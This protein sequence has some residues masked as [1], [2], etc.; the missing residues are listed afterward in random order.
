M[1]KNNFELFLQNMLVHKTDNLDNYPV[2]LMFGLTNACNLHCAFCPYCGFCMEKIEKLEEIPIYVLKKMEPFLKNASFINPSGRGE[3]L[4][5][6]KFEEFINI[7]RNANALTTMQLINNGTQLQ[8]IDMDLLKGINVISISVDSVDKETFELLRCGAKFERVINN[9]KCLRKKLPDSIL[10][11]TVVVNRLNIEQIYDIYAEAKKLGINYI[12]YNDVFGYEEDKV[13]QLLRIR[14]SDYVIIN[15]QFE[16]IQKDNRCEKIVINNLISYDGYEDGEILHRNSIREKLLKLKNQSPYL[17]YDKINPATYETRKIKVKK[18]LKTY[19]KFKLPYCTAP[20]M[21][22]LIMPNLK[23][24]PCCADFG[25][26]DEIVEGNVENVWRGGKFSELREAM[27]NYDMLPEYCKRCSSFERYDYINEFIE[28]LKKHPD[29]KYGKVEIPPNFFPP[30]NCIKDKEI[31]RKIMNN[32][33]NEDNNF[34][35][36]SQEYWNGRFRTDWENYSGNEQTKY[37]A[38]LLNEM[39]PS[40]L[41]NE[42]NENEYEICDLG[43]AEGDA[44]AVY[45]KVFWNSKLN[46]EDFSE[47]AVEIATKKYPEFSFTVGNILEPEDRKKYPVIICSNVVEHFKETYKVIRNICERAEKYVILLFPYCEEDGVIDEHEKSFHTKDI[48]AK[49]GNKDLVYAKTVQCDSVLYPYEQILLVYAIDKKHQVLADLVEAVDSD[50][51]KEKEAKY[52]KI[53]NEYDG[54]NKELQKTINE[55][56]EEL[57]RVINE[58]NE[59]LKK[60]INEKDQQLQ[61]YQDEVSKYAR[62][63][64]MDKAILKQKDEY[65][66]Q[67]QEMC[68]LFATGK[69]MKLNHF[70]W[71][72]KGQYFRGTKEERKKFRQWIKGKIKKT[73]YSIGDGIKFNPW[74]ILDKKLQ[75]GIACS[76]GQGQ[77]KEEQ[78]CLN[79]ANQISELSS[80]TKKIIHS[81]Y[82]KY[83]VIVLSVIDYDFRYQRPQ[84]FA[85][86]FAE[87]G[88]RVFYVNANF[89]KEYNI[90]EKSENLYIV[91][92]KGENSNSIYITNGQ[93]SLEWMKQEF[94]NLIRKY[95][96]SD[97]LVLVDYPNWVYAAEYLRNKFGFKFV[98]DYMDDYTGFLGTAEDFLKD[99]CIR[100]LEQSD[101]I[102]SSSQFLYDVAGKHADKNKISIIRNGTEV[103]HF[104]QAAKLEKKKNNRKQIG[105]YGAVAHWFAWEKVCYLARKFPEYDIVIIGSIT[106]Y[107]DKLKQCSNIKLI[108]EKP[109]GE[110]PKYLA[111]FDVCLIPFDTSTDLIKA[112]N[113]VKFYEYLS[114]GKKIVATEIPELMPYRDEYVYMSNDNEKFAAYVQKCLLNEDD[115]K[116]TEEDIAFAKDNDWQKRYEKLEMECKN[117]VPKVSIIVLTYNNLAL[118]KQCLESILN[119]TAYGNYELIIV[120]NCSTDGT[121]GYLKELEQQNYNN[122]KIIFNE[123]N[124]GFA[125]GNNLGIKAVTGKYV[126]L[127]N[128][129]TVVSR[130]WITN[131]VKHLENNSQYGMCNPVTNSIGNESKIEVK[132]KNKE[133]MELFAYEYTSMHMNEEYE[134]VDRLPLFATIIN[135][136]VI[137]KVGL[138]DESYKIGMFEDDDYTEAV[139]SAGYDITI[140]EDA[141]IHH[142]NN[143]SF[144]KMD[145]QKYRAIFEANKEVY[146]KKWGLKWKMPKYRNGVTALTNNDCNV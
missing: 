115:L 32:K 77:L 99:N 13:I 38:S 134:D 20:F 50:Y 118:N 28:L 58:K 143:A 1:K 117:V 78:V 79:T 7:C 125:G 33:K 42:I 94:E 26:I 81:D 4:L 6:S 93:D 12:T 92:F 67:A 65:M 22:M 3:P 2:Q 72:L 101:W 15:Q 18:N 21:T 100:L 90:Q 111:E 137:E 87:N 102:V 112:T 103:E 73:N 55:K 114:A 91:N 141:F 23:V 60:V 54:K 52:K 14:K 98:T 88:H 110:L 41:I 145:D 45:R 104:Y 16:K 121:V 48:P 146:E 37:F 84:H 43:C 25:T 74:M 51:L 108:G 61:I 10:Q 80:I 17:N 57:Q 86:R 144:K 49:V 113:P 131:M 64:L 107:E 24:A 8:R 138:L 128:N 76:S 82:K 47:A 127:L 44:L 46:G 71:R 135:K 68:H 97:A 139:K 75:D 142:V 29:F 56:N 85:S 69:I 35:I 119:K 96:I 39:V 27:F 31:S 83:D 34:K 136:K 36:N 30:K 11:W 53:I 59:E 95:A 140:A 70:M 120:D 5:Y 40:W 130:G 122:V 109:Y 9:V 133:E 66:L 63:S 89:I 19:N 129:D 132:Y 126:L 124:A 116:K 106:E 62:E 123:E 105:Y